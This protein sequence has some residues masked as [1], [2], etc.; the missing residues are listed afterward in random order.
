[1][2][3]EI[4]AEDVTLDEAGPLPPPGEAGDEG[5]TLAAA[6][7]EAERRTIEAA[8][9]RC[10]GDLAAVARDLGVSA[11]TLWRKMKRLGFPSRGAPGP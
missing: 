4:R 1:V 2:E 5:R 7:E 10:G 8:V 6:V 9:A 11:T 3:S